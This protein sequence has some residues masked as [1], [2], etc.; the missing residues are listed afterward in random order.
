MLAQGG[1]AQLA[2]Q[3]M[4]RIQPDLLRD[5]NQWIEWEKA[6]TG[7]YQQSNNW[8]ALVQRVDELPTRLPED[9]MRWIQTEQA[10]AYIK[11]GKGRKALWVLQNLIW[12]L[13]ND[14]SIV[15]QWL[16]GWRRLVI[17]SYINFQQ[18]ED[19]Q[20][21]A[22]RYYQ[23]TEDQQVDDLLLRARIYLINNLP[24]DAQTI[25]KPHKDDTQVAILYLLAQ[26]RS[27]QLAPNK[28]VRTGL[29]RLKSESLDEQ[30]QIGYWAVIAEAAQRSGDRAT[31]AN[32]L[33]H[34]LADI[35]NVHLPDGL[36]DF[37]ADSLW[38]SYID[39]ATWLGN[40][41]QFLIG[42]DKQWFKA[43]EK[44]E[45]K[46]PVRARSLYAL[47]ML[48]GQDTQYRT[49]ATERFV[50]LI[51]KRDKGNELLKQL[52]MQSSQFARQES[53]PAEIKHVLV[54]VALSQ[55]DIQQASRLMATIKEPPAGSDKFFWHLRRARIFVLGGDE[56]RGAAALER[57]VSSYAFL[58]RA[59]VDR[60]LQ[61]VFDLQTVGAHQKAIELFNKILERTTDQQVQ[62]EIFFWLADSYK[63]REEN[64]QAARYYLKSA[65]HIPEKNMDPWAQT[66]R[67]KAA[68]A[69]ASAGFISD[70]RLLFKQLL[71]VTREPSR[72]AVLQH[73]LQKLWL[74]KDNS[75]SRVINLN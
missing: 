15:E 70:A 50:A 57:L 31:A 62:R 74:L 25:P 48:K 12:N 29:Q 67:Y 36:F 54:D 30:T 59:Q 23:A 11:L 13:P 64:T 3:T 41:Q 17:D 51:K 21:A 75:T 53:M 5:K 37:N 58:P 34:V 60:L 55:S 52:F 16:P 69:L 61:V 8:K 63:A 66:S 4:D 33:E 38:N 45:Q 1:A 18:N 71:A 32:A 6:R 49:A 43:A 22:T 27:E 9:F 24:S 20:V 47:L 42:E 56:Q 46:L 39:F 44:A 28:V 40:R 26:L 10:R 35:E 19:A 7:I 72:R 68:E 14:K 2:L 73:E 65:T